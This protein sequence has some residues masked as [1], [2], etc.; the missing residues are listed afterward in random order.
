MDLYRTQS[1]DLDLLSRDVSEAVVVSRASP[2]GHYDFATLCVLIETWG[3]RTRTKPEGGKRRG[4]RGIGLERRERM[5]ALAARQAPL[6]RQT[7]MD[8]G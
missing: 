1:N 6:W 4:S 5:W 3:R 8:D 2:A 7:M